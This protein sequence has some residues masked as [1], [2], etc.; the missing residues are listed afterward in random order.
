M[1]H[2]GRIVAS[3]FT[4]I[5]P[6]SV[7]NILPT[8]YNSIA[9]RTSVEDFIISDPAPHPPLLPLLPLFGVFSS[10]TPGRPSTLS[11]NLRSFKWTHTTQRFRVHLSK[12]AVTQLCFCPDVKNRPSVRCRLLSLLSCGVTNRQMIT[13][14]TPASICMFVT[15]L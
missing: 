12:Q 11:S 9:P 14:E 3:S 7:L 5:L 8:C 2:S 13:R 1:S 6:Q 10:A 15:G 4:V